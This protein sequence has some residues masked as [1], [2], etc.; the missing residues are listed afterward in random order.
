MRDGRSEVGEAL[1]HS[2]LRVSKRHRRCRSWSMKAVEVPL[3]LRH[4]LQDPIDVEL[5]GAERDD[6]RAGRR[7]LSA[8]G[9]HA[10]PDADRR[11][12]LQDARRSRRGSRS[13]PIETI[14]AQHAA[15]SAPGRLPANVGEK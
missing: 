14:A 15:L 10:M 7:A 1:D 2:G 4:E 11:P 8:P 5:V 13:R 6:P 9:S 12:G 3:S